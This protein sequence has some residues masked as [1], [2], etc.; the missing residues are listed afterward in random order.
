MLALPDEAAVEEEEEEE[1]SESLLLPPF[2]FFLE[3]ERILLGKKVALDT[4][5]VAIVAVIVVIVAAA[6]VLLS[7]FEKDKVTFVLILL[8]TVN[9]VADKECNDNGRGEDDDKNNDVGNA[10]IIDLV[11][12][13]FE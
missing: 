4:D 11:N 6:D 5:V 10:F 2:C 12:M 9:C 7:L 3:N 13:F 1:D 8:L